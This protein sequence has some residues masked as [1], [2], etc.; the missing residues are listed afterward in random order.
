MPLLVGLAK[1]CVSNMSAVR[2]I[3]LIRHEG[4]RSNNDGDNIITGK[5][6]NLHFGPM[7]SPGSLLED[8]A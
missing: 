1:R 2:A 6:L 8:S 3:A 7:T 5:Y 4:H